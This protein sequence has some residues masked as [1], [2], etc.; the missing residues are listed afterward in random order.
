MHLSR[1]LARRLVIGALAAGALAGSVQ[2]GTAARAQERPGGKIV[3][4]RKDGERVVLHMM[5][6]DGTGDRLLPGQTAPFNVFP[7][8][9]R[10]GK[11][12]AWTAADKLREGEGLRVFVGSPDGTGVMQLPVTQRMV[13]T[14]A[15]SPDARQI[16]YSAGEMAPVLHVADAS[17]NNARQVGKE[18]SFYAFPFWLPDGKTLGATRFSQDR[19]QG[20]IVLIKI[21]TGAEEVIAHEGKLLIAG[22]GAVSPDG[23]RLLIAVTDSETEKATIAIR[24]LATGAEEFVP[25]LEITGVSEPPD[26]PIPA[27]APDGKSFLIGLK[28]EKGQ[29]IF[30]VTE[31]GKRSRITPEGVEAYS[32]AWV[33]AS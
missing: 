3:Y 12:V 26:F 27:W 32:A 10:D 20:E 29:A 15:W 22:P 16:A 23:K 5:N 13:I 31:D 25:N 19:P 33:G 1:P 21:E 17:G 8:V 4:S 11:R 14:P 9:S 2:S 28:T 7:T 6:A 30:R 24:T 18:G